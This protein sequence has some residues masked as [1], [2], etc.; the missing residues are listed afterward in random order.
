MF[1]MGKERYGIELASV[2]E[3][4]RPPRVTPLPESPPWL[5]G[6]T[7]L[8]GTILAVLDLGVG[9]GISTEAAPGAGRKS[10]LVVV[11]ED[12]IEA[13]FCVDEVDGVVA[14]GD[15]ELRHAPDT[16]P[17]PLRRWCGGIAGVKGDLVTVLTPEFLPGLQERLGSAR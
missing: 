4:R 14:I 15:G 5:R 2:R 6:V 7:N 12:G 11:H 10:R 17:E 8:R 9:L 13:G 1:R 3:I 16:L